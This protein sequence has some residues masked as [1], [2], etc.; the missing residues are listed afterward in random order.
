MTGIY[1]SYHKKYMKQI[2]KALSFSTFV[3]QLLTFVF[4]SSELLRYDMSKRQGVDIRYFQLI[5]AG[6]FLSTGWYS[7]Q[8][9]LVLC[10][11]H[12][13]TCK[14]YQNILAV[15]LF[16]NKVSVYFLKIII[17]SIKVMGNALVIIQLLISKKII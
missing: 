5:S 11:L 16:K 6:R 10:H 1:T 12:L 2:L 3:Y 15:F 14:K 9:R 13:I 7:R 4:N 8:N 17:T